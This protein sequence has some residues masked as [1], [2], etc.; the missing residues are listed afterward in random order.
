MVQLQ[1]F[2]NTTYICICLCQVIYKF[3]LIKHSLP[4]VVINFIYPDLSYSITSMHMMKTNLSEAFL[5]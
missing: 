5:H 3:H 4:F 2:Q 1:L